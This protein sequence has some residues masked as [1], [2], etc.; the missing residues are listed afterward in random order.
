VK[1]LDDLLVEG[2]ETVV[3]SLV[4]PACIEIFRRRRTATKSAAPTPRA[5]SFA[6]TTRRRIIRRSS[7]S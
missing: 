2:R 7:V 6:T 4:E 3:L 5:P 1:P